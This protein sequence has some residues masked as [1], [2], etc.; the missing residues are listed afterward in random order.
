MLVGDRVLKFVEQTVSVLSLAAVVVLVL[1]QVFYRYVLSSGILWIDELAINLMVLMVLFGAAL[2]TRNGTH[3]DL[4]MLLNAAPRGM[5]H[6]LRVVGTA[7]SLT[8]IVVLIWASGTY[9]YDSRRL[10]T[11]MI[12]IPLWIAY[13][14]IPVGS[15]LIL[16]E[17]LKKI[18]GSWL[19]RDFETEKSARQ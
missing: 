17:M 6:L 11:T 18:C 2:A 3:T 7:V 10:F 4:Q 15:V 1:V 5:Q 12:G 8:F 9:A 16:Y 14:I 13:G 19:Q